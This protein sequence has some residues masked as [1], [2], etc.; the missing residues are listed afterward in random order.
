MVKGNM[1]NDIEVLEDGSGGDAAPPSRDMVE[2]YM[3]G[4]IEEDDEMGEHTFEASWWRG[5]C[6][7]ERMVSRG[8]G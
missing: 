7:P 8:Q 4:V 2:E 1:D 5:S 6:K 3:K